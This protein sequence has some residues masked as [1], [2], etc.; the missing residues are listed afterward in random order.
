MQLGQATAEIATCYRKSI[1]SLY[2]REWSITK[3]YGGGGSSEPRRA[4][5]MDL[6]HGA[7]HRSIRGLYWEHRGVLGI[8]VDGWLLA[9]RLQAKD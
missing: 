5:E 6:C 4:T 9:V 2:W 8:S 3:R 1:Y 7:R